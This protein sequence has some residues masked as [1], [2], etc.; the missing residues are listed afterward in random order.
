MKNQTPTSKRLHD[1]LSSMIDH[2]PAGQKLP[3]EPELARQLKAPLSKVQEA[4]RFISENLN[5]FPARSHWGDQRQ[6]ATPA[7]QVYHHPDILIT[8]L[9]CANGLEKS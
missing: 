1:T 4:A 9:S 2:M 3:S 7:A 8:H 6:P 5:P